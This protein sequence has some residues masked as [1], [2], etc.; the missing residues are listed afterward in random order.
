VPRAGSLSALT[1]TDRRAGARAR[2]CAT[3]WCRCCASCASAARRPTPPCWPAASIPCRRRGSAAHS[4]PSFSS[5]DYS[6]TLAEVARCMAGGLPHSAGPA[7]L[8]DHGQR[9]SLIGRGAQAAL[10]E[11]I[12]VEMGFD[13]GCGRLDVSVHPFTGGAP[14]GRGA[15]AARPRCRPRGVCQGLARRAGSSVQRCCRPHARERC[16]CSVLNRCAPG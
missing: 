13:L 7:Q 2:R 14:R 8:V 5:C 15:G 11:E 16:E 12:A 4:S 10:C 3:A 9:T 6:Q 1:S